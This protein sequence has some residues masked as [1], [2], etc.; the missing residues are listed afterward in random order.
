MAIRMAAPPTAIPMIAPIGRPDLAFDGEALDNSPVGVGA[1]VVTV[2]SIVGMVFV[3]SE[4]DGANTGP[5][6][7]L[8]MGVA[9]FGRTILFVW[10]T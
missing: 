5:F 2:T 9:P 10:V 6:V 1:T 8:G 4:T 3:T 7:A